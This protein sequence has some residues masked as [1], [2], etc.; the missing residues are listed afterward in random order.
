[1]HLTEKAQAGGKAEAETEA[2]A[3]SLLSWGLDMGLEP[4]MLKS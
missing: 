1:M 4:R 3:D 2:E